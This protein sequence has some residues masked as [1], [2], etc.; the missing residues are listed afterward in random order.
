MSCVS[1]I[2]PQPCPHPQNWNFYEQLN[3]LVVNKDPSSD[4]SFT[5]H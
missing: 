3:I 4:I 1:W 5:A 2:E